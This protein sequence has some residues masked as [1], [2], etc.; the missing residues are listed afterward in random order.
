MIAVN[1]IN[2]MTALGMPESVAVAGVRWQKG[3]LGDRA[4]S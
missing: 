4:S 3:G 1:A 2:Q